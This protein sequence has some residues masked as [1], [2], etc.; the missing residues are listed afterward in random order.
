MLFVAVVP[1]VLTIGMMVAMPVPPMFLG[2]K[3][4]PPVDVEF[5][6]RQKY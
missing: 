6:V 5:F 3:F 2:M 1:A 4:V